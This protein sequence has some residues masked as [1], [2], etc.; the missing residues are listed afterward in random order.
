M[1]FITFYSNRALKVTL[2]MYNLLKRDIVY[3]YAR[4]LSVQQFHHHGIVSLR[5]RFELTDPYFLW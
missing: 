4:F 1:L 5:L 2:Y 3:P